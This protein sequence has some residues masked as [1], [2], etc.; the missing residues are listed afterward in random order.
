V[1]RPLVWVS[2]AMASGTYAAAFGLT[3]GIIL[4][5]V[6]CL[7]GLLVPTIV[8]TRSMAQPLS[9]VFVF[10]GAGALLWEAHHT[11]PPGDALSRWAALHRHAFIELEGTVKRPDLIVEGRDYA[12][13][14]VQVDHARQGD[15]GLALTGRTH[16]RWYAPAKPVFSDQRVRV[17]GKLSP[18]LGNVNPGVQD[19]EDYLRR[20]GV[21][22]ALYVRDARAVEVIG[23]APWWSA[24]SWASRL[25]HAE[26]ERLRRVV[27]QSIYPFIVAVWLGDRRDLHEHE[28]DT[29]LLSGTAH[30]LA[31]SG[32]HMAI[33]YVSVAFVLKMLWPDRVRLRALI[34]LGVVFTFAVLTG[35]RV[36]SMRAASMIAL[37]L[38]AE[39]LD[40]E[41]DAPTALGLAGILF[42]AGSPDALL[43]VGFL[44]S[45]SSVASLLLFREP[46]ENWLI[47]ITTPDPTRRLVKARATWWDRLEEFVRARRGAW[48]ETVLAGRYALWGIRGGLSTALAVQIVPLPLAVHFFHILPLAGPL[49]NLLV[50]PLVGVVLWMCLLTT[51]AAFVAPP[52]APLFGYALFVPVSLIQTLSAAAVDA[53][54]YAR[55]TSPAPLGFVLYWLLALMVLALLTRGKMTRYP[56]WAA[57]GCLSLC[58]V[59]WSPWQ[60]PGEAVFLDVGHGDAT[61]VRTPN[62]TTLLVDAG[63]RRGPVDRGK[64]SVAPFLWANHVRRLDYLVITHADADHIGGAPYLLRHFEVGE[65]LLSGAPSYAR[66]EMEFIAQCEARGTP[67]RRVKAGDVITAGSARITVLHPPDGWPAKPLND[68]SVVLRVRWPGLDLLLP[69]DIEHVA[70]AALLELDCR[71]AVLKAPHHASYTSSTPAF[72]DAVSPRL[73]VAS[74]SDRT[75]QGMSAAVLARYRQRDIPILRTDIHGAV[76][77][78]VK[79][80][81]LVA[82]SERTRRG[83]T[84]Q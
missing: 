79:N 75:P 24:F 40:R 59:F 39:V 29:F 63:E 21:H 78:R 61:F 81:E 50:V 20:R 57:V 74:G 65:V 54:A 30:I 12:S 66:L 32:V 82:R 5:I 31:V 1:K 27:P 73:V 14:I 45:F 37:Y 19:I 42:M 11:G 44:L 49:V 23:E 69:G 38:L 58:V 72:I 41:A 62:G 43:D 13:F 51:L 77:L 4:P 22:T 55:L 18:E 9:V 33:L 68:A 84:S 64:R 52:I 7:L 53:G 76:T 34:T 60:P 8:R 67:V 28:Q 25:R 2:L 26:A 48:L 47:R 46:I 17:R 35:A 36:S 6:S 71:A 16:I 70:E 80:G 56:R 83:Y 10:A 15:T 3:G